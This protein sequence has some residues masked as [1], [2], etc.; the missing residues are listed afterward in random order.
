VAL[1]EQGEQPLDDLFARVGP[2]DRAELGG[3]D[4]DDA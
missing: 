1:L 4:G 3:T 2:L